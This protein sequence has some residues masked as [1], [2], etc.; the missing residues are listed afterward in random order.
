[1]NNKAV[2]LISCLI[3]LFDG[4]DLAIFGSILPDLFIEFNLSFF[5]ASLLGSA[6]LFGMMIGAL[7]LGRLGDKLKLKNVL[8][9]SVLIF[10][11]FIFL[12]GFSR[13][14]IDFIIF[15]SLTGIGLGAAIPCLVVYLNN[16]FTFER[17]NLIINTIL[18]FYGIGALL[19]GLISYFFIN[20]LG[21]RNLFFISIF[22]L[23]LIPL[24]FS[25]FKEVE[26]KK[27][28]NY[29][30]L[31]L[32]KD[33]KKFIYLSFVFIFTTMAVYNVYSWLPK[34]IEAETKDKL[35][36]I[37]FLSILNIGTFLGTIFIGRIVDICGQYKTLTFS[38][39][40]ASIAILLLGFLSNNIFTY[41]LLIIIGG[42]TVGCMASIHVFSANVFKYYNTSTIVSTLA[43]FGRVGAII[44]PLL[45]GVILSSSFTFT[46]KFIVF[47]L[48]TLIAFI[49]IVLLN[50]TK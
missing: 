1:M 31:I 40:M 41:I 37:L 42:T 25:F 32:K 9:L 44:G 15:R 27:D 49:L 2:F 30:N 39:L 11:T 3:V 26:V 7:T 4:Y 20:T 10:S 36:G 38:Y 14:Y 17:K 5:Q 45:G 16:V 24:I 33:F 12:T 35:L 13:D 6:S 21:W 46:E 43:A 8:I 47:S 50:R 28:K 18:S 22:S 29:E 23:F 34:A 19:S 48:P